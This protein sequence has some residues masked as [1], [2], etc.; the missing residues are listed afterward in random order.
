MSR[1]WQPSKINAR[2]L[3]VGRAS[4]APLIACP[5]FQ[6]CDSVQ[7]ARTSE[8]LV[9]L[10]FAGAEPLPAVAVDLLVDG[11]PASPGSSLAT[12]VE[13]ARLAAD[14][15]HERPGALLR[16]WTL[17][18]AS[19][20]ARVL[21]EK[22]V[23][24]RGSS[25]RSGSAPDFVEELAAALSVALEPALEQAALA[26]V[27]PIATSVERVLLADAVGS[28]RLLIVIS[29]GRERAGGLNL[30]CGDAPARRFRASLDR[31]EPHFERRRLRAPGCRATTAR[32]R[33]I[34]AVWTEALADVG[35][36]S[37]AFRTG[38]VEMVFESA[39]TAPSAPEE[40]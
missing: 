2:G 38:H 15:I 1:R 19:D 35:A 23:P 20:E 31:H 14:A 33:A 9:S 26:R 27:S 37:V 7:S 6:G 25:L 22:A 29:D 36:A 12:V 30:E 28:D 10:G 21:F 17:A 3:A 16:I 34:G 24:E 8:R 13:E 39:S 4:C 40:E 5:P 18:T 32:E 11:T